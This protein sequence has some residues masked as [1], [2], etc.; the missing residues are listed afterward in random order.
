MF[1]NRGGEINTAF[2]NNHELINNTHC[3]DDSLFCGNL[4]LSYYFSV[5]YLVFREKAYKKTAVRLLEEVVERFNTTESRLPHHR[6]SGGAAGLGFVFHELNTSLHLGM[7][8]SAELKHLDKYLFSTALALIENDE[9]DCL[10]GAAGV[11]YYF[12][13]RKKR[14]SYL[15]TLVEKICNKEIKCEKGVWFRNVIGSFERNE[16]IANFSLSHGLSGILTILLSSIPFVSKKILQLVTTTVE[17]GISFI[18]SYEIK[19]EPSIGRFSCFPPSV[20]VLRNEFVP[21]V[22]LAWC[23]GDLGICL[24][25]YR[26]GSI[27]GK[28]KLIASAKAIAKTTAKRKDLR[29]TDVVDPFFCHGSAG[30]ASFY[31]RLFLEKE[32]QQYLISSDFWIKKTLDLLNKNDF[33]ADNIHGLLEGLAGINLT[34]ISHEKKEAAYWSKVFFL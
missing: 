4:G 10:H 3:D 16:D 5:L 31:N 2:H 11:I 19:P 28:A 1:S 8:V 33:P 13:Q 21:N 27:L 24:L 18:L 6:Y 22:R 17:K 15:D 30:L 7:D 26:A 20:H 25:L 32:E 23:Y 34:L 29:E 14:S 12:T 9:I